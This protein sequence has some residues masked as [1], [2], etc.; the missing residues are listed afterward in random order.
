[1]DASKLLC[2]YRSRAGT[3]ENPSG[4][5]SAGGTAANGRKGAPRRSVAPGERVTLADFE[6]P[7][8]VTH[9]WMTI[10]QQGTPSPTFLRGQILEIAYRELGEAA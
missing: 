8:R 7:G 4:A 10:A 1:M 6:G 9:F 3:F 2:G 5:P